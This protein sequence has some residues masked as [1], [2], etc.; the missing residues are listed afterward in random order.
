MNS[1]KLLGIQ[2]DNDQK[3]TIHF[4]G[5]KGLLT[6]LNQ[7]VFAIIQISN[8]I[9]GDKI[10]HIVKSLWVSKLRYGLQ[11]TLKVRLT[12]DDVKTKDM[13]A[14]QLAQNKVLRLLDRSRIKDKRSVREM[15]VKFNMLSINRTTI[16]LQ[17]AWKAS[18]DNKYPLKEE[19]MSQQE[20]QDC[21]YGK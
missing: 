21:P 20:T 5:T 2:M 9:S 16:K 1:A 17:E 18:L 7:R 8:Q 10:R 13:K 4:W 19:G 15:L 6:S 12:E 3:W 14:T 11:L